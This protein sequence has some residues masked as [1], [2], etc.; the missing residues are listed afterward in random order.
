M[1]VS[2]SIVPQDEEK[3]EES[4]EALEE[5]S[6]SPAAIEISMV[7]EPVEPQGGTDIDK[8][9]GGED[10]EQEA[11]VDKEKSKERQVAENLGDGEAMQVDNDQMQRGSHSLVTEP[12]GDKR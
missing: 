11:D 3:V 6:T 8:S 10:L 5:K 4:A 9:M 7:I 2:G 12:A 1:D